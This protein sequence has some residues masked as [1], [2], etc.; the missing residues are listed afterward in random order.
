MK[1]IFV[2]NIK[3]GDQISNIPFVV[4]KSEKKVAKNGKEYLDVTLGDSTGT[5]LS[6]VWSEKYDACSADALKEGAVFLVSGASNE[7][8][9]K[10]QMVLSM[11]IP[12]TDYAEEDFV[13]VSKRNI[14]EMF[15]EITNTVDS[16]SDRHLKKLLQNIFADQE[17]TN[18]FKKT[19]AAMKHHHAFVGGL[20][21]HIV[22]MLKFAKPMSEIYQPTNWDLIATGIILH[23]IGK[24]EEIVWK[25]MAIEYSPKG[26]LLGHIQIGLQI[27]E[28]YKPEDQ[29]PECFHLLQHIILAHHGKLEYGSAVVPAT[30][31]AK[32]VSLADDA[33]AKL[34]GYLTA[35]E[36]A[37]GSNSHFSDYN[38][39]LETSI[40][41][42]SYS[43]QLID[44][45][46]SQ[47]P[48]IEQTSL[49]EFN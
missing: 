12:T 25:N 36:D 9:G 16:I 46:P 3:A 44:E 32:I 41:L 10:T 26:K 4:V 49:L 34:R 42:K 35:Y 13:P 23:D 20:V 48:F 28:K 11:A 7:F 33:S 6:K 22:E 14:D 45:Q 8:M 47:K 1:Q 27:I 39:T 15:A 37:N 2:K 19:A 21:E 5:I 18:K 29:D 43:S 38:R 17:F 40:Y 31:E 30:I 24:V